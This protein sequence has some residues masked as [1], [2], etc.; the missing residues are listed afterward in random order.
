MDLYTPDEKE[1]IP[2][3]RMVLMT[4]SMMIR[5]RNTN[6]REMSSQEQTRLGAVKLK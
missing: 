2:T 4:I 1:I 5:M 6:Q 3:Q